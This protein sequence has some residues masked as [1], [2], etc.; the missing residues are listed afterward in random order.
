MVSS[1]KYLKQ[2]FL[3]FSKLYK[4]AETYYVTDSNRGIYKISNVEYIIAKK[5]KKIFHNANIIYF[6]FGN[7]R[8]TFNS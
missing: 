8:D 7:A 6:N 5:T 4:L 1:F 3:V 2:E